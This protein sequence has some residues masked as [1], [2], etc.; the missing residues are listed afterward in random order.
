MARYIDFDKI[1]TEKAYKRN[2]IYYRD[3]FKSGVVSTLHLLAKMPFADVEEVVRCKD[4]KHG[5]KTNKI[6]SPE[7][8]FKEDCVVCEC[9]DVVGDE[10]MIYVPTHFCSCG[11]PKERGGEK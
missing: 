8:F 4:C 6:M 9:E 5:R 10:P 7:K 1:D 11:T 2:E 3:S